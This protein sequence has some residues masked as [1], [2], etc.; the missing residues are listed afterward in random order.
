MAL[1]C[2]VVL[3]ANSYSAGHTPPPSASI[4][5]YNNGASAVVV[6]G[7]ELNCRIHGSSTLGSPIPMGNALPPYGPGA[8][9]SV[10]AGGSATVGPFPV[11]VGSAA[12]GIG[13]ASQPSQ[14]ADFILVVGAMVF[15]SDGSRNVAGEAGI[16]VSYSLRPRANTQG[17]QLIF[18]Q[19]SNAAGWFF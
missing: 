19:A 10:A 9:V 16:T 2:S 5:C 14:P 6:N 15:G 3:S 11:T 7:V 12:A 4:V 8:P 17:G 13:G 1:V 18:S